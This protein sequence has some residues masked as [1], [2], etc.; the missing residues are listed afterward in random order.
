MED[1][2]ILFPDDERS[3][4]DETVNEPIPSPW[5]LPF[6]ELR[7]LMKPLA[8]PNQ[9]IYRKLVREGNGEMYNGKQ[10]RM[11]VQYS[12]YWQ[13]ATEPFDSSFLRGEPLQFHP[14]KEEVLLGLE[15]AV[16]SMR[17]GEE[18]L[19][20][21]PYQLLFGE[22]GCPER[23]Q[24]KADGLYNIRL[25]NMVEVGDETVFDE[26]SAIDRTKFA[27]VMPK[28]KDVYL[29]GKDL[30]SR[31]E[32]H[33]AIRIFHKAVNSLETCRISDEAQQ[34]EQQEFLVKMY[35]N[36]A[37]CYNKTDKPRKTCMMCNEIGRISKLDSNC[38]ALFQYGRALIK[39]GDYRMARGK[40]VQAQRLQPSNVEI[41]NELKLLSE[42][43]AKHVQD[44]RDIWQRAFGSPQTTS[45]KVR[46][47]ITEVDQL[48]GSFAAITLGCLDDF[49]KNPKMRQM[50]LPEGLSQRELD[51]VTHLI[52]NKPIEM[53]VLNSG[54]TTEYLL[55]KVNQ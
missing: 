47:E 46:R 53:D 36:L 49:E 20:V 50:A 48:S 38:K 34:V 29:K 14:G 23:I 11:T 19:F 12:S 31:G 44:E 51:C 54:E 3:D 21:I 45:S 43:L 42:V 1:S 30:F 35:T 52:K 16:L 2:D 4:E 9:T 24:P 10:C 6:D 39:L 18:S 22:L 7:V 33:R 27:V 28:A 37:V 17:V 15:L 25:L 13:G 8:P 40:L 26:V 5:Q 55:R 32:V 41:S